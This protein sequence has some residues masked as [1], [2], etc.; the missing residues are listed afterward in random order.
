VNPLLAYKRKD[1]SLTKELLATE[2]VNMVDGEGQALIHYLAM[3]GDTT[4]LNKVLFFNGNVDIKSHHIPKCSPLHFAVEKGHIP[5]IEALLSAGADRES[6]N[7][8]EETAL[9]RVFSPYENRVSL[10]SFLFDNKFNFHHLRK[11]TKSSFFQWAGL[12]CMWEEELLFIAEKFPDC[13]DTDQAQWKTPRELHRI[14][15]G[16]EQWLW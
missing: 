5:F 4:F 12:V 1:Y 3:N 16:R 6:E 9:W 2:T 13:L 15:K 14:G 11:T 7:F 10:L 8:T